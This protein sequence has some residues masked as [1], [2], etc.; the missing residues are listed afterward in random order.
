MLSDNKKIVVIIKALKFPIKL[1]EK[2]KI[3]TKNNVSIINLKI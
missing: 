1:A 3:M 2:L